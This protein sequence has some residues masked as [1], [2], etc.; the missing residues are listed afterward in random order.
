MEVI[1]I[2]ERVYERK[3]VSLTVGE[4]FVVVCYVYN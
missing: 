2:I 4:I 3:G 1:S